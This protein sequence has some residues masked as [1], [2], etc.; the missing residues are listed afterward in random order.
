MTIAQQINFIVKQLPET[1]QRLVFELVKRICTDDIAIIEEVDYDEL[2]DEDIADIEEA[3][4]EY[5]RGETIKHE[6]ID[7][8]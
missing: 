6:D 8:S 4:A 7:W 5:E 2:T 3:R 1:E